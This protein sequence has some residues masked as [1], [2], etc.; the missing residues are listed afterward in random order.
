MT[1]TSENPKIEKEKAIFSINPKIY[2]LDIVYSAA[3]IMIDRAFILLD[4]D[5]KDRIEVEIRKKHP[6]QD[7]DVLVMQ[8]NEELLNYATYRSR[9]RESLAFRNSLL[10]SIF[11]AHKRK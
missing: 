10:D 7:I 6:E 4:G 9:S 11:L 3:Y 2:P 8:F 1:H 5:P